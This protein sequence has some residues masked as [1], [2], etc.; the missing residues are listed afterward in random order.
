MKNNKTITWILVIALIGIWGAILYR[1]YVSISSSDRDEENNTSAVISATGI[2]N[3][4]FIYR[5]D[6]RDPFRSSLRV[7][8]KKSKPVKPLEPAWVP[9]PL[10]LS[11]IVVTKNKRTAI[12]EDTEGSTYF[13]KEGDVLRGVKIMKITPTAVDYLYM[14]KKSE[15]KLE[16]R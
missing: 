13:V 15:W 1:I 6:V 9:P 14:K 3:E 2:Q 12:I 4:R 5:S 16:N 8:G 11:G 10:K 7:E